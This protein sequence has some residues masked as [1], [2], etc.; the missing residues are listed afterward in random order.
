MPLAP[1]APPP[2]HYVI[3]TLRY[4]ATLRRLRHYAIAATTLQLRDTLITPRYAGGG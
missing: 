4:A 1:Y 3:D 2:P